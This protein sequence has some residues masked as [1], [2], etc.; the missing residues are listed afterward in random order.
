MLALLTRRVS[1]ALWSQT[2]LSCG[3]ALA[4]GHWQAPQL[5]A[6]T[7]FAAP[8][9]V[10]AA[11]SSFSTASLVAAVTCSRHWPR[12]DVAACQAAVNCCCGLPG[13]SSIRLFSHL[14]AA[15]TSGWARQ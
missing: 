14:A 6:S 11:G 12:A 10:R 1:T 9:A 8:K 15:V 13:K 2:Y 5:P 3:W 7:A 4:Q